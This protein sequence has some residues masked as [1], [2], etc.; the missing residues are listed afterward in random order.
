M[1]AFPL[2]LFALLGV[3]AVVGLYLFRRR[4]RTRTVSALF[5]W[6]A[7][8]PSAATGRRVERLRTDASFWCELLAALILGLLVAGPRGCGTQ[9]ASHL[10]CILDGSASMAA[11]DDDGS[12]AERASAWVA[13]EL[14]RLGP[15]SRATL[16]VSGPRPR[17]LAGPAASIDAARLALADYRPRH[18]THDLGATL[19]LAREFARDGRLLF[20]TDHFDLAAADERT[21]VRSFGRPS[22]NVGI[23]HALRERDGGRDVAWVTVLNASD[24]PRRRTLTTRLDGLDDAVQVLELEPFE[25]RVVRVE[26]DADAPAVT[27]ELDADALA[28]DDAVRL[29]P[30]PARTLRVHVAL[31]AATAA[32][33]GIDAAGERWAAAI[34]DAVVA[35][36]P[37]DAHLV[38]GPSSAPHSWSFEFVEGAD[39][40][41]L[42]PFLFDRGHALTHGIGLDGAVWMGRGDLEVEGTPIVSSGARTLLAER[43]SAHRHV[44]SANLDPAATNLAR[45][46]DW[47]IL[48]SNWSE[49]RRADLPGPAATSLAQGETLGWRGLAPGTYTLVEPD[50]SERELVTDGRL[51]LDRLEQLGAYSLRASDGAEVGRFAIHFED[52]DESNLGTRS[53]GEHAAEFA[54]AELETRHAALLNA[55]WAAVLALTLLDA[56]FL[57][58]R[59]HGPA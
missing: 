19:D 57:W 53:A 11:V 44:L 20:A 9:R 46:P 43:V 18:G 5:L 13:D 24:A 40:A 41:W 59:R 51:A 34:G 39:T 28:I 21:H 27:L 56:Y 38:L 8:T 45:T 23:V 3:P 10:V 33:L 42:G 17:M 31:P 6:D 36:R 14:A 30:P 15:G 54:S 47:P 49:A 1:F 16:L 29:E 12:A 37:A 35:A 48:L 25:R 55:L 32:A 26:L 7:P 22:P 58:S 2:G 50:G 52:A 4:A